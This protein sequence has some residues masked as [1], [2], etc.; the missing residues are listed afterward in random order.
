MSN[1]CVCIDFVFNLFDYKLMYYSSRS[2]TLI[3]QCTMSEHCNEAD[4]L[5]LHTVTRSYLQTTNKRATVVDGVGLKAVVF[6][7]IEFLHMFNRI[8]FYSY[9]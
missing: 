7:R 1:V 8:C 2:P 3:S 5:R 4:T 9:T 6:V